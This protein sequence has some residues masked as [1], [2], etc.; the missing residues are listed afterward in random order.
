MGKIIVITKEEAEEMAKE[1]RKRDTFA[2]C[3]RNGWRRKVH[4]PKARKLR[5]KTARKELREQDW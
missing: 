3:L 5:D 4:R 1:G 2:I